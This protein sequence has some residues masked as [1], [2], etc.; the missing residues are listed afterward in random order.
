MGR[1]SH[2]QNFVRGSFQNLNLWKNKGTRAPHKPLLAVWAIGRCLGGQPRL[3]SYELVEKELGVLLRRFGPYRRRT[4]TDYPF[5]HL[6][7]D[8][9]WA[10]DRPHLVRTTDSGDAYVGDLRGQC[11]RGRIHRGRVPLVSKRPLAGRSGCRVAPGRA[12]PYHAS[13]CD[14]GSN[15]GSGGHP[16]RDRFPG[17]GGIR[18]GAPPSARP[19]IPGAHTGCVRRAVARSV[20]SRFDWTRIRSGWRPHT[21]DGTRPMDPPSSTTGS[22]CACCTTSSSMPALSRCCRISRLR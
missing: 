2:T 6:R 4:R 14:P 12:F 5:W 3:A 16:G 9:V 21:F 7:N 20:P 18:D 1:T 15:F 22:P 17:T 8:G 19:A 13:R 10:I 11:I